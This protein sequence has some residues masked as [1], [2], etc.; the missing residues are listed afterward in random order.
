[1]KKDIKHGRLTLPTE[2]D[3]LEE[4][5]ELLEKWG[6][7]AIRNSDGTELDE[8]L[9]NLDAK[10]Y[11]TY[12]VARGDNEFALQHLDETQQIFVRTDYHTATSTKLEINV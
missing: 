12:F 6:A 5:Q 9:L 11:S 4:T 2:L 1:M 8:T 7:D 3:F 10:V